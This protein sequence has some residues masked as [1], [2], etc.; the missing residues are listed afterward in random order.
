VHTEVVAL[1]TNSVQEVALTN[2]GMSVPV[3]KDYLATLDEIPFAGNISKFP[4]PKRL[5]TQPTFAEQHE[6]P[7]GHIPSYLPAFPDDHAHMETPQFPQA[8]TSAQNRQEKLTEQ[9]Q[10]AQEALLK[11]RARE[12]PESQVLQQAARIQTLEK[13]NDD[14]KA[15]PNP[16]LSNPVWE[17]KDGLDAFGPI[18]SAACV[19]PGVSPAMKEWKSL[20]DVEARGGF[21]TKFKSFKMGDFLSVQDVLATSGR[22]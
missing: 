19:E 21:S 22:Y 3:L 1:Y 10:K 5:S 8:D 9:Q 14:E 12:V 4:L 7:P 16:F 13:E 20:P 15:A 6:N 18:E 17:G 11:V 2:L